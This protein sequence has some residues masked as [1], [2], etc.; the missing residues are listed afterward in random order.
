[1]NEA[2][3]KRLL[4]KQLGPELAALDNTAFVDLKTGKIASKTLGSIYLTLPI[5][6]CVRSIQESQEGPAAREA[7]CQRHESSVVQVSSYI[8]GVICTYDLA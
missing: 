8:I 6:K 1:M 4:A 2:S 7:D 5:L 3:A